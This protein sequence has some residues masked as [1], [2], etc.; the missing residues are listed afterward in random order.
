[1][2]LNHAIIGALLPPLRFG[3]AT[4]QGYSHFEDGITTAF[5]VDENCLLF[6]Q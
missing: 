6:N 3:V 1:M 2:K 4:P 5:I